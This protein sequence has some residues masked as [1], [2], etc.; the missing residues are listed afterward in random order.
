MNSLAYAFYM[1]NFSSFVIFANKINDNFLEKNLSRS[2]DSNHRSPVFR[3]G[4]LTNLPTETSIPTKEQI[5]LSFK[6]LSHQYGELEIW[7]RI[8]AKAQIFS[9]KIIIYKSI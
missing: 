6:W 3:T 9:L 2:Q 7:V 4:S 8:P 1:I 5:S